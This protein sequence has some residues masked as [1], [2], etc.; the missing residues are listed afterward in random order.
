MNQQEKPKENDIGALPERKS[1]RE[2][3]EMNWDEILAEIKEARREDVLTA[4]KPERWESDW[5]DMQRRITEVESAYG[6]TDEFPR[7]LW[8]E[9]VSK[10]FM[11]RSIHQLF[12]GAAILDVYFRNNPQ[13]DKLRVR[14]RELE[15]QWRDVLIRANASVVIGVPLEKPPANADTRYEA[16]MEFRILP[17]VYQ[18]VHEAMKQESNIVVDP[19]GVG[20]ISAPGPERIRPSVVLLSARE[21]DHPLGELERMEERD[22]KR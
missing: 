15:G 20:I 4:L 6:N 1:R 17:E 14:A 11:N 21:W 7:K 16:D 13:M 18:K 12:R 22:R 5:K 10:G 2:G 8:D 9:I 3:A 19:V